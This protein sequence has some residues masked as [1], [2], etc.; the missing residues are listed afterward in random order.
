ML[1]LKWPLS[2]ACFAVFPIAC[3]KPAPTE[4]AQQPPP[5]PPAPKI[6][7]S[8]E[9]AGD[10]SII[11][12]ASFGGPNVDESTLPPPDHSADGTVS[13]IDTAAGKVLKT[14]Q[15]GR[16]PR[17]V[18]F[19]PDVKHAYVNAE[20]DGAIGYLD[21]VKNV[22]IKTIVPGKPGEI[23]PMGMA[24]SCRCVEI[25]CEHGKRQDGIHHRYSDES[26]RD[27]V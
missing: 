20:N 6:Y 4:T 25:V 16:R 22:L 13:V 2:A 11:D 24:L 7:V 12:S 10:I 14:V 3:S 27:V 21:T 23:K 18:V 26:A 1:K 15:V 5:A 9:V 8:D 19:M 17:N